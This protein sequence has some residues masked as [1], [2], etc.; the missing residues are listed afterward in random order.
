M[1]TA[2]T[3]PSAT[4]GPPRRKGELTA[5]RILDAA[6]TLFAE[7]GFEGT[8]LRDVAARVGLRNPSL[9]NHFASKEA[10]YSAVLERDIRPVLDLLAKMVESQ[11]ELSSD[12]VIAGTM[13]AL[14]D[15]PNVARLVQHET[16]S[17]GAHLT[18]ML[19]EFIAPVFS[20]ANRAATM[21]E[22][23][24]AAQVPL[25]VLSLYNVVVGYFT[26]ATLYREIQGEDLLSSEALERQTRFLIEFVNRLFREAPNRSP[27]D[28]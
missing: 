28:S 21:R 22:V 11:G 13:K 25:V 23:W 7:K 16:L 3:S 20:Q 8:K 27:S 6:E 19:R 18:G 17:G 24:P 9:Y 4:P 26:A 12:D 15:H 14:A 5:E 1:T 10:L 2:T